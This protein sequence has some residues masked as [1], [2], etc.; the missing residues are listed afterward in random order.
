MTYLV[1][2]NVFIASLS[3]DE[4]DSVAT[5]VLDQD[6]EFCTSILTLMEVRTVLTKKKSIEQAAV[7]E[8][9]EDISRSIAVY[10]LEREDVLEAYRHQRDSLLYPVDCLLLS[11][12]DDIGAELVTFD[13]ELQ[14]A[15][16]LP[17]ESL[18]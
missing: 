11:L 18:L 6:L 10:A 14:S 15:G 9:L 4:P 12:A 1:D 3:S 5:S 17:P 7:E 13:S 16:A 2:A 8:T